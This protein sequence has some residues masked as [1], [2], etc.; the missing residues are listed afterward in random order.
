MKEGQ[1]CMLN[2]GPAATI[3]RE[4]GFLW[5]YREQPHV[6]RGWGYFTSV[7][8]GHVDGFALFVMIPVDET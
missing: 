2:F 1:L 6:G 8:T 3:A 4:H 7:A 5:V